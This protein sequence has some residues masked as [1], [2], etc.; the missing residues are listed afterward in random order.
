MAKA[1]C[2][3]RLPKPPGAPPARY[4]DRGATQLPCPEDESLHLCEASWASAFSKS[5]W[6]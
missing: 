4:F 5:R 6:G 1:I 2:L 3:L